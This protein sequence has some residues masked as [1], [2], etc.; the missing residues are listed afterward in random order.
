MLK[1]I[2]LLILGS[3]DI[4]RPNSTFF[5]AI[6]FLFVFVFVRV[7]FLPSNPSGWSRSAYFDF[8]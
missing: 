6:I 2:L 7:F 3:Y 8:K 5:L 4:V 1:D